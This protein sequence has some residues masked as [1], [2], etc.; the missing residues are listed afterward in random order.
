MRIR[1]DDKV[2]RIYLAAM[3]VINLKG[4]QGSSMTKIATEADISPATIYLY[5]EN[6][7]DMINK[8]F[9]HLKTKMGNSFISSQVD[10][11]A[12][13]GTFRIIWLHHYQYII[14]NLEEYNFIENF[15]NCP[16]LEHVEKEDKLD[17][18]PAFESLFEKA[19]AAKLIQPFEKEIIFSLLFSPINQMVKK[20]KSKGTT[21]STNEL[22]QLFEASW[23]AICS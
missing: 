4:F 14:D 15:S 13:K 17:Y 23:R 20:T 16:L 6:K 3:K 19:K 18:Y 8:L 10:L 21:L 5:F 1:D 22:I 9:I 12:S 11:S 2:T 7:D